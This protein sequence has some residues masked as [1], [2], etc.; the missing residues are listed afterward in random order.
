MPK[1]SNDEMEQGNGAANGTV[2]LT[3]HRYNVTGQ[4]HVGPLGFRVWL[5]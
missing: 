4:G 2:N 5:W 1:Q 3:V